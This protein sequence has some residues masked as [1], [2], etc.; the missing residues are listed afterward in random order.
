[1]SSAKDLQTFFASESLKPTFLQVKDS[2]DILNEI[3][4]KRFRVLLASRSSVHAT[5]GHANPNKN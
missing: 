5:D 4:A 2:V 3:L 1:M